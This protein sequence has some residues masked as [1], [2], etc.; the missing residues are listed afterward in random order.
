[1]VGTRSA[2]FMP[3]SSLGLILM[4]EEHDSSYKQDNTPRYHTRDIVLFRAAYHKCK[5]IL[6][7]ATPS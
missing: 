6:A 2:C 3:F 4:D 1:M 7:S 5:V